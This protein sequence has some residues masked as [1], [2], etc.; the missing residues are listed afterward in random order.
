MADEL[1]D[2]YR[3]DRDRATYERLVETHRPMVASVCRRYLRDP[4]DVDDVVQETFLKLAGHIDSV[5]GSLGAWLASTAQAASVDLIRRSVRERNRRQGLAQLGGSGAAAGRDVEQLAVRESIR[6]RLH[7]AL[8]V[9]DPAAREMLTERFLRKTPLRVLAGRLQVSVPTASRRAA[10]A[11]RQ[12]AQVLRDMGVAVASDQAVANHFDDPRALV[13]LD[14]E[15]DQD[16]HGGLRFAP[17]WRSADLSPLGVVASAPAASTLLPGWTRPVRVGVMISYHSTMGA[18]VDGKYVGTKW[19]VHTSTFLPASGLQLVGV[20][21]PGTVHRG[22]VESTLREYGIVGG[23]IEADDEIALAT[24][25]VLLL[26]LN[27]WMSAPVARAINRAVRGGVGLLNE[28]WTASQLRRDDPAGVRELMLADSDV[29]KYHMPP[30]QCGVGVLP[31][32]VLREHALLPGLKTGQRL[33]VRGCGPAYKVRPGAQLLMAKDYVVP[34]HE[35]GMSDVGPV[36]MPCYI[37]GHLGRGRVVVV[38]AWPHQWF[39]RQLNVD[40]D[41][42]FRNLLRWLAAP[43][44]EIG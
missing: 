44:Q 6:L 40:P 14:R 22:V 26:G 33:M 9:I 21:E 30:G 34:P 23:L 31:M 36:Q 28:F 8:L 43:R 12:L 29:Y 32:T 3:C 17:D 35:H 24:L 15:I 2:R 37:I 7:E 5:S 39:V 19:Q 27:T 11:L 10:D 16:D 13:D 4:E 20:V 38:H 41:E 42:Y 1:F 18:V 25:D